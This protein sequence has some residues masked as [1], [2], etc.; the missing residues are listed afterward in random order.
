MTGEMVVRIVR[1]GLLLVLLISAAPMLAS[2]LVGLVVSVLQAT[3]QVQEQTLSYVPKLV[4]VF[5]TMAVMGPWMLAQAL[6]FTKVIFDSIA[7]V[8]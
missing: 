1:E 4:A 6:R 3:T 7:L 2:M 8:R 5:L